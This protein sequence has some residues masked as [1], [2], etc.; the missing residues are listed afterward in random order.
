MQLELNSKIGLAWSEDYDFT[1]FLSALEL[2][3]LAMSR[4]IYIKLF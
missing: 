4:L 3:R 2:L 1:K